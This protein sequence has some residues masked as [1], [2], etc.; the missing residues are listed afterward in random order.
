MPIDKR[1]RGNLQFLEC[2]KRFIVTAIRLQ[3][4]LK[5]ILAAQRTWHD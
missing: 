1:R 3:M 2:N 4:D 5:N